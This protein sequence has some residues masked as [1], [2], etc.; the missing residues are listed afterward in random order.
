MMLKKLSI[1]EHSSNLER[2]SELLLLKAAVLSCWSCLFSF[3]EGLAAE[4]GCKGTTL[5]QRCEGAFMHTSLP[6]LMPAS[7][8]SEC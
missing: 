5:E 3:L 2:H 6:H 4:M 8:F 1:H 7:N